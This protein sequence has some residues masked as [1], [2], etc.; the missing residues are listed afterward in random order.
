M[1]G[2]AIRTIRELRV[3]SLAHLADQ[4]NISKRVLTDIE[5]GKVEPTVSTVQTIAR[6]LD[7]NERDLIWF[8]TS[9][10]GKGGVL[11]KHIMTLHTTTNK[12]AVLLK[13]KT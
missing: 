10:T 3:M 1:I 11:C 5:Q 9:C 6:V 8:L 4:A 7:V 13:E 12:L 2:F